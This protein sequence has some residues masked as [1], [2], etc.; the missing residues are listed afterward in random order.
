MSINGISRTNPQLQAYAAERLI[1]IDNSTVEKIGSVERTE[2]IENTEVI[3][4][5]EKTEVI[6]NFK[7]A[8]ERKADREKK[9]IEK[10][11]EMKNNYETL[12]RG[13][14]NV[15]EQTEAAA[16]ASRIQLKCMKIAMRIMAGDDV[17]VKDHQFL[18][19][20]APELYGKAIMMRIQKEDPI[21]HKRLSEDKDFPDP[22]EEIAR[23]A[24]PPPATDI[25][26][27]E[28]SSESSE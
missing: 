16:E 28:I 21:K 23:G 22:L 8:E 19:E 3:E 15:N 5:S 6:K 10:L 7:S 25:A 24:S 14:K 17:P 18:V 13:L 4:K 11:N 9:Q 1:K 2:N 27:A 12:S 20:H 26:A